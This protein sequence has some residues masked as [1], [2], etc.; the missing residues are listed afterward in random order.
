MPRS[1]RPPLW[2]WSVTDRHHRPRLVARAAR[3]R[4]GVHRE[5]PRQRRGA[6]L[7]LGAL[8]F[9]GPDRAGL[10][11]RGAR[12]GGSVDGCCG[13]SRTRLAVGGRHGAAGRSRTSSRL[14][15]GRR[16]ARARDRRSRSGR[17]P[18]T[19]A[20]SCAPR[21][22]LRRSRRSARSGSCARC[23]SLI[24]LVMTL[25]VAL[26]LIA[27]VLTGPLAEAIGDEL[28]VGDTALTISVDRQVAGAVRDRWSR[29]RTAVPLLAQ[30]PAR[31]HAL[32]PSR[33][34]PWRR[35]SGWSPRPGSASTS[36]TSAPTRTPTAASPG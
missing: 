29:D 22:D 19:S 20:P 10:A 28:G 30:R 24:T 33:A 36:P 26:V 21:T 7:L 5:R 1:G 2:R 4:E 12:H 31:G 13:S 11:A 18:A 16:R 6:H 17:P 3:R 32:D 27:L 9:P 23:R 8:A 34:A 35:C 15:R 14:G 25:I